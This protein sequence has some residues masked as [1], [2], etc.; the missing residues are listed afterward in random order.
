MRDL[1]CHHLQRWVGGAVVVRN[2]CTC[3]SS[4]SALPKKEEEEVLLPNFHADV[5]ARRLTTDK[6]GVGMATAGGVG[7]TDFGKV[8]TLTRRIERCTQWLADDNDDDAHKFR[9]ET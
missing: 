2:W 1:L 3:S 4:N 9:S 8:F 7:R 6:F 5:D